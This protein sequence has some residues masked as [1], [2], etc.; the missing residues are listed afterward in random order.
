MNKKQRNKNRKN[1]TTLNRLVKRTK[2]GAT[3][4][5][6]CGEKG[7]HW[8]LTRGL[9]LEAL[10]TGVDDQQGFWICPNLYDK[11]GVRCHEQATE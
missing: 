9:S 8:V 10:I 11:Q 5:S 1:T 2:A 6:N 7:A 3:I 4:C